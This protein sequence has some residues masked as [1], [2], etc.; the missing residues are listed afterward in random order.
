M[1][2]DIVT[3]KRDKNSASYKVKYALTHSE[4]KQ[5][6][7]ECG[8]NGFAAFEFYLRVA[9]MSQPDF[10]DENLAKYF[11]WSLVTAKRARLKLAKESWVLFEK[12]K[13]RDGTRIQVA[14]LGIKEVRDHLTAKSSRPALPGKRSTGDGITEGLISHGE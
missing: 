10:S 6:V 9:A 8:I 14:H 12:A 7:H 13:T 3:I 2:Y 4:R 11:G 1:Y 5:L